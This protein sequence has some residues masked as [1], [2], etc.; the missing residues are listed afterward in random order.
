LNS[1]VCRRHFAILA[2]LPPFN[3]KC[4][5]SACPRIRVHSIKQ[6]TILPGVSAFICG[7]CFFSI[8]ASTSSSDDAR[9][10]KQSSM[11]MFYRNAIL[12]RTD[13]GVG[14]ARRAAAF[15][16]QFAGKPVTDG[17]GYKRMWR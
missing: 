17:P 16:V 2:I 1:T 7:Q 14:P 10:A 12:I 3:A 9:I 5:F 4:V 6:G 15:N 8:M 11:D 13:Q